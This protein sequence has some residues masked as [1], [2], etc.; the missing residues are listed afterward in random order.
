M[1]GQRSPR[2]SVAV[3]FLLGFIVASLMAA[4]V[5]LL[6]RRTGPPRV[7]TSRLTVIRQI[8]QLHRLETVRFGMDKI[9]S[10][11]WESRYLP[12]FLAGER[13][14]LIVYGEVTEGV[15]STQIDA[16]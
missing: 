15:D 2:G 10:G 11:G 4:A 3:G 5:V 9:V 7:D 12:S 16:Q 14:L 1:P 8:Q 13:L 6:L